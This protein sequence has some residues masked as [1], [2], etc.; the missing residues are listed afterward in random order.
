[1][2]A[3]YFRRSLQKSGPKQGSRY[4]TVYFPIE[5]ENTLQNMITIG[6]YTVL[7]AWDHFLEASK[8][9]DGSQI[10]SFYSFD[11]WFSPTA[12]LEHKYS[13]SVLI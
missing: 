1:M 2:P 4:S 8:K 5:I 7:H 9:V 10:N 12:S 3:L 6:K 11:L 13:E